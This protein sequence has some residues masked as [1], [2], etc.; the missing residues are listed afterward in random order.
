MYNKIILRPGFVLLM[1]ISYLVSVVFTHPLLSIFINIF[2]ILVIGF[3]F[4]SLKRSSKLMISGLLIISF[5]LFSIGNSWIEA[6]YSFD[7]NVSILSIFIFVPL[8]GIP[9]KAAKYLDFMEVLY[10]F[11]ITSTRR[12]YL[13]TKL[14][15]YAFCVLMNLGAVTLVYQLTNTPSYQPYKDMRYK[16][17]ARGYPL[18]IFWSPYYISIALLLSYFNVSWIELFPVGFVIAGMGIILGVLLESKYNEPLDLPNLK[19]SD[20]NTFRK[21]WYK[22]V[23]LMCITVA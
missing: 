15:T 16:A 5:I 7:A 6:F 3:Y 2:A 11:Y 1:G 20:S 23:E 13:M 19:T 10:N 14:M 18:A 8:L 22:V 21:A 9:L 17:L 12:L 4:P